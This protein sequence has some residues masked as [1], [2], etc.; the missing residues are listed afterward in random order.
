MRFPALELGYEVAR[1]NDLS[2][3]VL[4]AAN[5]VAVELFLA[6]RCRFLDIVRVC[7]AVLEAYDRGVDLPAAVRWATSDSA[8]APPTDAAALQAILAA[9]RWARQEAY[10]CLQT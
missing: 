5:E 6:G 3:A 4:N 8:A 10:R 9:D 1:R 7:R 2:G